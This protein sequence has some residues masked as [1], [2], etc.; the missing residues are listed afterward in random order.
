MVREKVGVVFVTLH[1]RAAT[2]GLLGVCV[3]MIVACAAPTPPASGPPSGGG[4]TPATTPVPSPAPSAED[5]QATLVAASRAV[6]RAIQSEDASALAALVHPTKGVRF[7]ISAHVD[8]QHDV[9]MQRAQLADFWTSSKIYRWGVQD[10]TGDPIRSTPATFSKN[11]LDDRNYLSDAILTVNA[12]RGSGTVLSN[13]SKVYPGASHVE[14]FVEPTM[15]GGQP[16]ND[17]K[18]VRLVFERL[19]D[20]W[21]LVGVVHAEWTV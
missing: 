21:F 3:L 9:V 19:G 17:W 20:T 2:V 14:Y 5:T 13:I 4:S 15:V 1:V 18:A 11:Y 6:L 7:S 10:A 12:D 16:G 8:V